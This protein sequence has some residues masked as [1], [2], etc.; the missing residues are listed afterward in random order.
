[1]QEMLAEADHVA[2]DPVRSRRSTTPTER[3]HVFDSGG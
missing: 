1:M 2:A 3:G